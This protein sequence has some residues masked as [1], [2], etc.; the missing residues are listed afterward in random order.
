MGK[1]KFRSF[2]ASLILLFLDIKSIFK[3]EC[4]AKATAFCAGLL[5]GVVQTLIRG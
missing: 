3:A 4:L 5:D 2:I 1:I